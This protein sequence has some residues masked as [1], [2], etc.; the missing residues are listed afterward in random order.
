ML[1]PAASSVLWLR[2]AL[3]AGVTVAAT[4]ALAQQTVEELTVVGRHGVG[5]SARSISA[6]VSYRD[7]DLT[8]ESGRAMLSQRVRLTAQDLCRQLGA[9]NMGATGTAPSCE[10]DAINSVG[11]QRRVAIADASPRALAEAPPSFAPAA[12]SQGVPAS[13]TAPAPNGN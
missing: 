5:P 8:T 13:A 3:I 7:L 11:E 12:E 10:Q 2:A 6:V 4:P 9:A 1:K